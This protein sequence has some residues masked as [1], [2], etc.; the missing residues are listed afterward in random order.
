MQLM[1]VPRR[2]FVG[3]LAD[4]AC[5]Q[6]FLTDPSQSWYMK[7]T[8]QDWR[9]YEEV[10]AYIEKHAEGY[11]RVMC[12]GNCLGA[13]GALLFSS[14]AH[15]TVAF[16][17]HVNFVV[18]DRAKLW[19][20]SSLLPRRIRDSFHELVAEG[21]RHSKGV[22]EVHVGAC[23]LDIAQAELLKKYVPEDHL[24]IIRHPWRQ[25]NLP[26]ELKKRDE[27]FPMVHAA[28]QRMLSL[29]L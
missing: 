6:I 10:K 29:P 17:P 19:L 2:E 11:E 27:L 15:M 14:F 8:R 28:Y 25:S 9:G 16:N 23:P 20:G 7:G 5:D 4:L 18:Q 26:G 12:I 22:V 1:K 21:V 3:S 13:S 24:E